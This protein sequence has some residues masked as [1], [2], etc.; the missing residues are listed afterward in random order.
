MDYY[1]GGSNYSDPYFLTSYCQDFFDAKQRVKPP[2]SAARMGAVLASG[3]MPAYLVVYN[4]TLSASRVGV[5][6]T[7]KASTTLAVRESIQALQR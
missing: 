3:A 5:L 4:T 1:S 7:F 2:E 6:S